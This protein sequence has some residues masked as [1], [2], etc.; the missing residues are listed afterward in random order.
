MAET[1]HPDTLADT[2]TEFLSALVD[3]TDLLRTATEM[4]ASDPSAFDRAVERLGRL[5]SRCDVLVADVRRSVTDEMPPSFARSYLLAGD[6]VEA[7]VAAD[8]VISTAETVANELS[9][10]RPDLCSAVLAGL[11]R[12]AWHAHDA[13]ERLAAVFQDCV[14]DGTADSAVRVRTD[15]G[16]GGRAVCDSAVGARKRRDQI[17]P[18]PADVRGRPHG[19]SAGSP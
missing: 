18:A 1:V 5:E 13:A 2:V 9:A 3:G 4:Y 14:L 16:H 6:V 11:R 7:V 15:R 8:R 19:R 17:R 10:M 12:M